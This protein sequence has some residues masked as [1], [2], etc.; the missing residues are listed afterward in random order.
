MKLQRNWCVALMLLVSVVL[1]MASCTPVRNGSDG[2]DGGEASPLPIPDLKGENRERYIGQ[3]VTVEGIFVNDPVPMLVTN[4]DYVLMNMPIPETEY[5]LLDPEQARE[6]DAAELGGAKLK[7]QGTVEILEERGIV[8]Q[9][10]ISQFRFEV[11]ERPVE[12]YNPRI[13]DIRI[14]LMDY[15]REDRFAVLFSGGINNNSNHV[16]YWNDLKFMYS[17]LVN[18]LG[19]LP[20]NILVLYADGNGRDNDVPVDYS[21]TETNLD[22][23]FDRIRNVSDSTDLI[24]FFTTNFNFPIFL[25]LQNFIF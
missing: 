18:T 14:R 13:Q 3:E 23:A 21:A 16:R 6:I 25:F 1:L 10:I 12:L 5:V 11:V 20:G 15:L 24:F 9:I 7:V 19:F 2:G 17:T 8:D 22:T 4:L